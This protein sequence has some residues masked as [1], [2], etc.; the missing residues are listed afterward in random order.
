MIRSRDP[1][2]EC[3]DDQ[4]FIARDMD[5][6]RDYLN[7]TRENVSGRCTRLLVIVASGNWATAHTAR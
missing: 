3:A 2:V 1:S 5:V 6:S 4:H 7:S